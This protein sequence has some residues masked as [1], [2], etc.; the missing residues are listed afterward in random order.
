MSETRD[1]IY[2][3]VDIEASGPIPGDYSLLSIGACVVLEPETH[4]YV[5]LQ[6]ISEKA[7]AEALAV[8]G[9][10]LDELKERGTPPKAA[11]ENFAQWINANTGTQVPVFVGFNACFDW[12]FI[13]WYFHHF[14]GRNPFG[15]GG[16]DI[17]SYYMGRARSRWSE[18]TSSQL[19]AHLAIRKHMAHNAL[20]DAIAQ[21]EL[22]RKLLKS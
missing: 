2:I 21:G 17:K 9:F 13:N 10:S 15:I 19:P 8:T 11:M 16:I 6:P 20:Q 22:V 3:S 7:V 4:F 18:T 14:L 1:E 5:E 12:A